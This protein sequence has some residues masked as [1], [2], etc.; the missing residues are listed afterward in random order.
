MNNPRGFYLTARFDHFEGL[1]TVLNKDF[2]KN[3]LFLRAFNDASKDC[4]IN[5]G[6]SSEE[7]EY[8]AKAQAAAYDRANPMMPTY[9][10]SRAQT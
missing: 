6:L 4:Y 7:L 2:A 8:F 9:D 3:D 1:E 5:F 10:N